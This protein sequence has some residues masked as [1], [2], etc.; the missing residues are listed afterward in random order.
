MLCAELRPA[1]ASVWYVL[2]LVEREAAERDFAI[3]PTVLLSVVRLLRLTGSGRGTLRDEEARQRR[4]LAKS[5]EVWRGCALAKSHACNSSP[6][7]QS[8]LQTLYRPHAT[9]D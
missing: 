3:T 8:R 2:G 9:M 7:S 6:L 5:G 1:S 4:L